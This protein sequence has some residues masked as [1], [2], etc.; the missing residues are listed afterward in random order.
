LLS[1]PDFSSI[2]VQPDRLSIVICIGA[3]GS[4]A[5]PWCASTTYW[6]RS[7]PLR[8]ERT[9]KAPVFGRTVPTGLAPRRQVKPAKVWLSP[10]M[11]V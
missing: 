7:S 4:G 10:F 6:K 5:G 1:R 9:M 11:I 8:N 2:N 3:S